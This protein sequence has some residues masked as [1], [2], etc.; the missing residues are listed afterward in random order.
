MLDG[1]DVGN[2]DVGLGNT[3]SKELQTIALG[4]VDVPP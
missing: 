3:G 1:A 4:Q 2:G